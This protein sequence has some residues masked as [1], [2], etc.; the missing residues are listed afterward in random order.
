MNTSFYLNLLS[1][2]SRKDLKE[3]FGIIDSTIN[4]GIFK[5]KEHSS[6]W[7]FITKH[8]TPDRTPYYDDFDGETLIFEGQTKGKT[9]WLIINHI[10]QRNELITFY[11]EKKDERPDYSFK[12]LGRFQYINH[13]N[14]KP[15]RFIL[16]ALDL[17]FS[18]AGELQIINEVPFEFELK[19]GKEKTSIQTYFE[20]NPKLRSEAIK[21]HGTKCL[22]CS[23]DFSK[24]YG[25]HGE[26]FIEIHHLKPLSE[27]D[28]ERVINPKTDLIPLCS[29]CHR[30]IHR[31]NKILSLLELKGLIDNGSLGF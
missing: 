1:Y 26:G 18:D 27:Y 22:A 4:N 15:K 25:V 24:K 31:K 17:G 8:K 9:D 30:M 19:E 16:H 11:R 6:V 23:F 2:Y 10:D 7:I 20:R 28:G 14:D 29:N 3:K 12:Y 21:I 13:S 5:P